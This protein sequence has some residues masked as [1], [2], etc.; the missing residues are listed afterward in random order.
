MTLKEIEECAVKY[1]GFLLN[2][3]INL[4]RL[5]DMLLCKYFSNDK[6]KQDD[7]LLL[8]FGGLRITF[9]NKRGI[10]DALNKAGKINL[11]STYPRLLF[12]LQDLLSD[13]K[14]LAH[15]LLDLSDK[16]E[17]MPFGSIR[18]HS[19]NNKH[20][21]KEFDLKKMKEIELKIDKMG[22]VILSAIVTA[23]PS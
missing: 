21:Y 20:E 16:A 15:Y 12:D 19:L 18:F 1:R 23:S 17:N 10:L 7:L 14:V 11:H 8:V 9:D 5:C 4:E 3:I 22:E 6:E 2:E 13:R